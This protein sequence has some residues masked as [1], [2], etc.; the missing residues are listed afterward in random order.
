MKWYHFNEPR[1]IDVGS[2]DDVTKALEDGRMKR[3][4]KEHERYMKETD[5]EI[6]TI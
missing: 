4:I 3:I 5:R 2:Y 1:I 6:W